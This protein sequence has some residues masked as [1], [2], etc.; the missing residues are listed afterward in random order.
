MASLARTVTTIAVRL[1]KR[2][3]SCTTLADLFAKQI[4]LEPAP[5]DPVEWAMAEASDDEDDA[6]MPD[7]PPDPQMIDMP[8]APGI[9]TSDVQ[10]WSGAS[11]WR[12]VFGAGPR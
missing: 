3:T 5:K 12:L 4:E 6:P 8:P 10:P 9:S 2:P 11:H 7:A 1:L